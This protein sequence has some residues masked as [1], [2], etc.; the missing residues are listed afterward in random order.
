MHSKWFRGQKEYF[1]PPGNNIGCKSPRKI[2][3]GISGRD[4]TGC[5]VKAGRE[6]KVEIMNANQN[7]IVE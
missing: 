4:E 6:V 5:T 3:P 1:L 2:N 7:I